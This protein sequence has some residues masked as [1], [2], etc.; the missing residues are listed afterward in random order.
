M[1]DT[2]S[3]EKKPD[4]REFMREKIV[5]QP[6]SKGQIAKRLAAFLGL[7]VT[8]GCIAAVSF[9]LAKP[10]ADKHLGTAPETESPTIMFPKDELE[11]ESAGVPKET[12]TPEE[13]DKNLEAAVSKAVSEYAFS[14]DTMNGL[15]NSLREISQQADKGIVTVRSGKQHLDLFGN[16]VENTGD[17]A[18]AVI[19]KTSSEYLIF[20]YADAVRQADTI[21]V[22]F[23]DGTEILGQSKQIDEVLNMAVVSVNAGELSEEVRKS[24]EVIGLGNSYSSKAGDFIIGV[25]GPAGIVHSATY[26][27]ISYINRNVRVVDGVMRILYADICSNSGTGTFLLNTAGEIIGWTA[28]GYGEA[29]N[30]DISTAVGISDYKAVLEKMIHGESAPYF[31]IKGQEV[32]AV[33]TE[34]GIPTGVYV[35]EAV[36]GSPAYD[37]G[38]QNGDII[39]QFGEKEITTFKELQ[40]Q[41]ENS[42]SGFSVPVKVMRKGREDYKELEFQ[43]NIR[44]R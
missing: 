12:I 6:L 13:S 11:P 9:V 37:A 40:I 43:V 35:S 27:T 30:G 19:A 26:G 23:F 7:A 34:A 42:E 22:T 4:K 8:F 15:Y 44:A 24:I 36:A 38:I 14:V 25:G 31:G 2:E 16:P 17:Y 29:E 28:E 3:P 33:M 32:N 41:I 20:T 39:T 1:P 18:G 21:A 5:K 10:L